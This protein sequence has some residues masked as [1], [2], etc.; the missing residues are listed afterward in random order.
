MNNTVSKSAQMIMAGM[1]IAA[2]SASVYARG[3]DDCEFAGR[4]PGG[5]NSERMERFHEQHLARLHEKLKLSPQQETAWKKYAALKPMLDEKSR[6]DPAEMA[7]LNAPERMEK[8]LEH[9]KAMEARMSEHLAVLKEFYAVLTPEQQ[10]TFDDQMPGF[11]AR[12]TS[13][14]K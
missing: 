5:M 6:P 1:A 12:R 14:G 10:K 4:G 8:G 11:G 2:L 3:G 7:K 9:M 13:R